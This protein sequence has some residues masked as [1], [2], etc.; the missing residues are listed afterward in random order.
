M[1]PVMDPVDPDFHRRGGVALTTLRNQRHRG[2]LTYAGLA[3]LRRGLARE[4][5]D[6]DLRGV[7]IAGAG[8]AFC[9]GLDLRVV[10]KNL[11]PSRHVRSLENP[12]ISGENTVLD[13]MLANLAAVYAAIAAATRPVV[14]AVNGAA[15]AGGAGLAACCHRTVAG[16]SARIGFPGIRAG[17]T[18]PVLHEPL[19]QRVG[20][21]R[22][23][24]LLQSGAMLTADEALACGLVDEVVPDGDCLTR[25]ITLAEQALTAGPAAIPTA[26]MATP[27]RPT[28]SAS[29]VLAALLLYDRTAAEHLQRYT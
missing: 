15:A 3:A 18:A 2:A 29:P 27:P 20:V 9:A 24:V 11:K 12:A 8:E 5:A 17:L 16:A 4:L 28:R 10:A 21:A 13:D 1:E 26:A 25:A 6:P 23:E 7:V 14:A 19:V 22:A